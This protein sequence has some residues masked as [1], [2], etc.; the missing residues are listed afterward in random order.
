MVIQHAKHF[1]SSRLK[2]N[3]DNDKDTHQAKHTRSLYT[4]A[5]I[6]SC[7]VAR[8]AAAAAAAASPGTS[9]PAPRPLPPRYTTLHPDERLPR[10]P[11]PSSISAHEVTHAVQ[12]P[13]VK[14]MSTQRVHAPLALCESRVRNGMVVCPAPMSYQACCFSACS[15]C[16]QACCCCCVQQLETCLV[17]C[18][19]ARMEDEK[20]GMLRCWQSVSPCE[21]Q[22]EAV[23]QCSYCQSIDGSVDVR[24]YA[25]RR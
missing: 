17:C 7:A 21:A 18:G 10:H 22:R 3:K 16:V 12:N 9:M 25:E 20:Q 4:P 13:C 6:T 19:D 1:F 5:L 14:P 2:H 11:Q 8:S 24:M 23:R 15:S